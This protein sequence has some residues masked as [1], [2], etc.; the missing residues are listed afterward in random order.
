[1]KLID[2]ILFWILIL[3]IIAVAL[4]MLHGS[5][6]EIGAIIGIAVFVASSEILI[7]RT[8][9]NIDKKTSIGF[10]KIKSDVDRKFFEV[11]TKLDK[12]ENLIKKRK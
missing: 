1:M 12:I 4:W 10:I 6:T 5:P 9:F 3:L 2:N 11:N 7:W 8:L